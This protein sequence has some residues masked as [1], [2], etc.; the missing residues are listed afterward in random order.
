MLFS[1]KSKG[2]GVIIEEKVR[3]DKEPLE[4]V[5][6]IDAGSTETRV[7]VADASD[8]KLFA[9][10]DVEAIFKAIKNHVYIIPS[11]FAMVK[12]EREIKPNSEVLSD[13]YDSRIIRVQ[14]RAEEPLINTHR[15]VR[16]QKIKDSTGLVSRYLDSSTNKV[17]NEIFYINILDGIG[18]ALLQ[19]YSGQIPTSVKIHLV[20]SVRPQEM[21]KMLIDRLDSNLQGQFIFRW[22]NIQIHMEIAT[23][24]YTTEPEA[25]IE[26]SRA[27][28]D[29]EAQVTGSNEARILSDKLNNSRSYIHIEGGGSSIGV[30]VI[31]DGTL[32]DG[33]S[34][35]FPLGGN[36]LITVMKDRLRE[37]KGR[38]ISTEAATEAVK[39]GLLRNGRALEDV[40]EIL[41]ACK[42]QVGLDIVER[43]RHDVIDIMTGIAL[44]D[45][46]LVTLGGRLFRRD[47]TG[48]SIADYIAE[49]IQQLSPNTEVITLQDNYIP[50]GNLIIGVNEAVNAGYF[51]LEEE[52]QAVP[53]SVANAAV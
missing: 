25:Q 22:K 31:L 44:T 18:Y 13:N 46:E 53:V 19:K 17:D 9:S 29:F 43:L 35:T 38:M 11:T 15:V 37:T 10:T 36:Y 20:L 47:E 4:L 33:C 2:S 48:V 7:A 12:D 49:Y 34:S 6:G 41:S 14:S 3:A 21:G 23:T 50:Q 26:G 1:N 28:L 16:G 24:T 51:K 40:G 30:E 32:I 5:I 42:N 45:F 52:P 39:T 8:I 27:L